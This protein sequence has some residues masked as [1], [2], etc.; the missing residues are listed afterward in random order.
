MIEVC[1]DG[2]AV[3][4]A[5]TLWVSTGLVAFGVGFLVGRA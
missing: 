5:K 2:T 4:I 3:T 1:L